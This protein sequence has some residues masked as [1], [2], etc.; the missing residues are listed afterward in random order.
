MKKKDVKIIN[1]CIHVGENEIPLLSGEVHYWRLSPESW[2]PVLHSVREMGLNVI[3]SY[4]CWE[5]HELEPEKYDFTGE[6]D[7]RRN[8]VAFLEL[9]REEG[10][11]LIFRPGPYIYS[12]W[13]NNGVPDYAVQYH[14]LDPSFQDAALPYM[15]AVTKLAL[16]YLASK[17]GNIILWQADNEIDPWPHWYTEELGLGKRTGVFQA[18][19]EDRYEDIEQLNQSWDSDYESFKNARAVT[20]LFPGKNHLISRYL[21]FIRFQQDYVTKV[22]QWAVGVYKQYGVDVPIYLNAYT[23]VST[24]PWHELEAAGDLSGFDIYPTHEMEGHPYEQRTLFEAVNYTRTYSKLPYICEFESGVWHD[25]LPEV[26]VLPPN[27][28][29]LS[30]L[31]ALQAGVSGW[32]WYMLADRDNWYQSPVNQWG[33]TRPDLFDAFSDIVTAYKEIRPYELTK[34]THTAATYDPLQR[35][36]VRPGQSLLQALYE[37]DVDYEFFDLAHGTCSKPLL[38]YAG[39]EWL[40][41][42]GQER[43]QEYVFEGGHLVFMKSYPYLD[44]SLKPLN[45]LEIQPPLSILKGVPQL[46]LNLSL[47]I[48]LNTPWVMTYDDVPGKPII[49][50]RVSP[51][52]LTMEENALQWK[53]QNGTQYIVGYTQTLGKGKITMLGLEPKKSLVLALHKNWGIPIPARSLAEKVKAT[54]YKSGQDYVLIATNI[55]KDKVTAHISFATTWEDERWERI[56]LFTNQ[57]T[58]VNNPFIITI[59]PK[60]GTVYR[61]K[62]INQ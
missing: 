16:P 32:N 44:D 60:N 33:R 35:A 10:F 4:V 45:L 24:Q 5:F 42:E 12:E 56:N 41:A 27:H 21:D 58:I 61:I 26:G 55:A 17:G 13:R 59:D 8:L 25:R 51:D 14:R 2:L 34:M 9:L 38:F 53:L 54:L 40:S 7:P 46:G 11:W 62:R 3:S 1:K 31:S 15:R 50:I 43:L 47:G 29:R 23:G 37:A 49:A 52:G 18:Y 39:G 19:L 22:A 6:T 20:A 30:C 28:Y 36:S 57:Q 48:S